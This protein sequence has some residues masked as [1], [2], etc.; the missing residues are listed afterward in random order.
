MDVK[1]GQLRSFNAGSY[2]A[3]VHVTGSRQ[4]SIIVPVSR[5]IPAVEMV[6]GRNVGIL[7]FWPGDP[8]AAVVAAVWP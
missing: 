7:E 5:A 8:R 2:E 1:H 3:E 4:G 6:A